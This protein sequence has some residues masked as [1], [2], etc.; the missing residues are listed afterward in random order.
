ME[1]VQSSAEADVG[2]YG[3]SVASFLEMNY[4]VRWLDLAVRMA[5][6]F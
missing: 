2:T 4:I 1:S 6:K 3:T 5:R